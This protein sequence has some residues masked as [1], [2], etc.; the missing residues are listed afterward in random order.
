MLKISNKNKHFLN[1]FE[2]FSK[3]IG[4]KKNGI[5]NGA[6]ILTVGGILAKLFSAVYRI[7]LTRILGGVG[8]GLYQL[9]FPFYSLC[10]VLATAGIPMAVSKIIA[11]HKNSDIAVL[12]KCFKY[13]LLVSFFL[14]FILLISSK[15]LANL[16][17]KTEI[18]VCYI[19]LAP[20]IVLVG[21]ASVLRG[22]F[23]GK[24]N[25][26]PSSVSN[27]VEQLI[28]MIFGLI[29]SLLLI[30]KSLL[31]GVVGAVVG[32]VISEFVSLGVLM[33]YFK[34]KHNRNSNST[35]LTYKDI[36]KEIIPITLTNIILPLAGF[37]DSVLVVNLLNINFSSGVSVFLYGLES[38]AVSSIVGLP[39]IFSYAIASVIMPNLA[40]NG[41]SK[42]FKLSLAMKIVLIICVPCCAVFIAS[43]KN[44]INL[45]Y[46]NSVNDL[47]LNGINIAGRLL[48][49]SA[50]GVVFLSVNQI[51]S[52]ALQAIDKSHIT[53]RNLI[54]AVVVKFLIEIIFMPFKMLNIYVLAIS[55]TACYLIVMLLNVLEIK[56]SFR[57]NINVTFVIKI[58]C[59]SVITMLVILML[60]KLSNN[61]IFILFSFVLSVLVYF[62]C[63]RVFKIF[64]KQ[65]FAYF[66]YKR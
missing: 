59:S 55:N 26:V 62:L 34:V 29:L 39:T 30:Q 7:A 37:V 36:G 9:V 17:S 19:I 60:I 44:I 11:K 56:F 51:L 14:T 15:L 25:F 18:A 64:N 40:G 31:L 1:I 23:Q 12:K 47:S 27:I 32:I 6:L 63:L 53:I 35:T 4:V 65:E 50:L 48:A 66:K 49:F 52:S 10:V 61:V 43:P 2:H 24:Q 33:V 13:T 22:Y 3:N 57:L 54:V 16:Q 8:I 41:G 45:L 58:I 42:S 46:A 21:V 38:G 20:S 5:L 28:K